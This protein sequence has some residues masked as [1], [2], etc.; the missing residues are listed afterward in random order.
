MI[1]ARPA[2]GTKRT[3][4]FETFSRL[5]VMRTGTPDWF[6]I[7]KRSVE[8]LAASTDARRPL[9]VVSTGGAEGVDG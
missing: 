9:D 2:N 4:S 6:G 3:F 5:S 8:S 1:S 7:G